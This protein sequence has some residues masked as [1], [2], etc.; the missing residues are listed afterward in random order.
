LTGFAT[1]TGTVPDAVAGSIGIV[2][3][4]GQ[5]DA[6]RDQ[7]SS[8]DVIGPSAVAAPSPRVAVNDVLIRKL[9]D[10]HCSVSEVVLEFEHRRVSEGPARAASRL[11]FNGPRRGMVSRPMVERS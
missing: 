5:G 11:V 3:L 2:T 1:S 10:G 9:P 7:P 6:L 8:E 4:I